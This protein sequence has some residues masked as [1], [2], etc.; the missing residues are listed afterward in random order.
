[1]GVLLRNPLGREDDP[2]PSR[3]QKGGLL[4]DGRPPTGLGATVDL[5]V[6]DPLVC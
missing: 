4:V 1:M 2:Q 5:P 3:K 6:E